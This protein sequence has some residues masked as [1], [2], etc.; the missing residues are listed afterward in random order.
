[1]RRISYIL[2]IL[3]VLIWCCD[4]C[5][6]PERRGGC[7]R[8]VKQEQTETAESED[9]SSE[10]DEITEPTTDSSTEESSPEGAEPTI[11]TFNVKLY[12]ENSGSMDGYI[13][14]S[15]DFKNSL[16]SY[17]SDIQLSGIAENISLHFINSQIINKG[18]DITKFFTGLN[19]SAA[20]RQ[21]GGVRKS[22]DISFVVQKVLE[23]CA[24]ND[25]AIIVSDF[26]FSPGKGKSAS[27]YLDEQQILL[28]SVF[29][30]YLKKNPQTGVMFMQLTSNFSGTYYN[31]EDSK[32]KLK[33]VERPYYMLIVGNR[34]ALKSL[35]DKVPESS[36]KGS[37]VKNYFI[38]ENNFPS[39]DYAVQHGSGDFQRSRTNATHAIA[40]AKKGRDGNL[41]FSVNVD[42]SK[43]LLD[44]QYLLS[45]DNYQLN[46]KQFAMKVDKNGKKFQLKYSSSVVK[47]TTLSTKL[48]K[49]IPQWIYDFDDEEGLD[50]NAAPTKTYGLKT[51][52]GGIT[53]AFNFKKDSY[54]TEITIDINK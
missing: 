27:K 20:F 45:A 16:H 40:N 14:G 19:S 50:I 1:M 30:D 10:S 47:K 49:K 29:A 35:R 46:D 23:N 3:A 33:E 18:N 32:T 36:I 48:L 51:I 25:V 39:P 4:G 17:M 12:I 9:E 28:K 26:I 42:F 53:E 6:N 22:T 21:S 43:S 38:T 31:R 7:G 11:T 52:I 8:Q 37:G 2:S 15:P 24:S 5:S 13:D 34:N 41:T 54:Y 44:E